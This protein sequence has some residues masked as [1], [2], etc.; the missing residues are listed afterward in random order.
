MSETHPA[1]NGNNLS[2]A[3]TAP[4]YEAV[5]DE[6]SE[7]YYFWN[8]ITGESTW[9][10]PPGATVSYQSTYS[11]EN[12]ASFNN[13]ELP[14]QLSS[15]DVNGPPMQ[16]DAGEWRSEGRIDV[17]WI[18]DASPSSNK[19]SPL[20]GLDP[21]PPLTQYSPLNVKRTL[22]DEDAHIVASSSRMHGM[23]SLAFP[24]DSDED[25][26]MLSKNQHPRRGAGPGDDRVV[27]RE[28]LETE[29]ARQQRKF[30]NMRKN[31]AVKLNEIDGWVQWRSAH[32]A[33][34][35]SRVGDTGGQW[36][37]PVPFPTPEDD[38]EDLL[39]ARKAKKLISG[40]KLDYEKVTSDHHEYSNSF[41]HDNVL[42]PMSIPY[43]DRSFKTRSR[44]P[45]QHPL[46]DARAIGAT[47]NDPSDDKPAVDIATNR[48]KDIYKSLRSRD[49]ALDA[50]VELSEV[51]RKADDAKNAWEQYLT[52]KSMGDHNRD[53]FGMS[54]DDR[55]LGGRGHDRDSDEEGPI[56]DFDALYARSVVVRQQWPWT[57]LV[58]VETDKTFY[59]NEVEDYFQNE[60]PAD[61]IDDTFLSQTRDSRQLDAPPHSI[62][63]VE[64]QDLKVPI[65]DRY[66]QELEQRKNHL[67]NKLSG[68]L[69]TERAAESKTGSAMSPSKQPSAIAA[70]IMRN[71]DKELG[72]E[73]PRPL[74][75]AIYASPKHSFARRNSAFNLS[76]TQFVKRYNP[77]GVSPS[78]DDEDSDDSVH[79][80]ISRVNGISKAHKLANFVVDNSTPIDPS[81]LPYIRKNDTTADVA[82]SDAQ[83]LLKRLRWF[84]AAYELQKQANSRIKK[85][86]PNTVRAKESATV[87][88]KYVKYRERIVSDVEKLSLSGMKLS[89]EVEDEVARLALIKAKRIGKTVSLAELNASTDIRR[90]LAFEAKSY[91]DKVKTSLDRISSYMYEDDEA[92]VTIMESEIYRRHTL[93]AAVLLRAALVRPH[94]VRDLQAYHLVAKHIVC[95]SSCLSFD[96]SLPRMQRSELPSRQWD[97]FTD[98]TGN[99]I[100]SEKSTC[101]MQLG[102]PFDIECRRLAKSL[103]YE[104]WF[105]FGKKNLSSEGGALP[106]EIMS[107]VNGGLVFYCPFRRIYH[108]REK[109]HVSYYDLPPDLQS[110]KRAPTSQSESLARP[111]STKTLPKV[112]SSIHSSKNS[113][114]PLKRTNTKGSASALAS[115]LSLT[116]KSSTAGAPTIPETSDP[117]SSA[118]SPAPTAALTPLTAPTV[119]AQG[120]P[121]GRRQSLLPRS[122]L[123][124]RQ[125]NVWKSVDVAKTLG[126]GSEPVDAH[127]NP[128]PIGLASASISETS[129]R[130]SSSPS[131]SHTPFGA[132]KAPNEY[133]N[134]AETPEVARRMVDSFIASAIDSSRK[135][136]QLMSSS[137]PAYP[138]EFANRGRLELAKDDA[139]GMPR[140][141]HTDDMWGNIQ[142]PSTGGS[143]VR[144]R[145][146]ELDM[147]APSA[148]PLQHLMRNLSSNANSTTAL[149]LNTMTGSLGDGNSSSLFDHAGVIDTSPLRFEMELSSEHYSEY[150][151]HIDKIQASPNDIR[152]ILDLAEFFLAIF[153]HKESLVCLTRVLDLCMIKPLPVQEFAMITLMLAKLSARCL[154]EYRLLAVLKDTVASCP[155]HPPVLCQAA[156]LYELIQADEAAEQLYIGALILDPDYNPALEGYAS[157]LIRQGNTTLA[158]RYMGRIDERYPGYCTSRIKTGW[159]HEL[160]GLE[161]EAVLLA[162][163]S[164]VTLNKRNRPTV[165]AVSALGHYHHVRGDLEK[166]LEYYKRGLLYDQNDTSNLILSACATASSLWPGSYQTDASRSS[167][168][169]ADARFRRGIFLCQHKS[170]KWIGLLAYADFLS[171]C[172]MDSKRIEEVLWE[173]T[174]Y[175]Y[176]YMCIR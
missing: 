171:S 134:T 74:A 71:I 29:E 27:V 97:M 5:F 12:D 55:N 130:S 150:S 99:V 116:S 137:L 147:L 24:S 112:S 73:A 14:Q 70:A 56:T 153:L 125:A 89:R 143:V 37:C 161:P 132:A 51:K 22:L 94:S 174:R 19:K 141:D 101:Q 63:A 158:M 2:F 90:K 60:T 50:A 93:E 140:A 21:Q 42:S 26:L 155:D 98:A 129:E 118:P 109:I 17:N 45:P 168:A 67:K 25:A 131:V 10:L 44:A 53:L 32:G 92:L 144:S 173:A 11:A 82:W 33:V 13:D 31:G 59:R 156:R 100:Y 154:G 84:S 88:G 81:L 6:S 15:T 72:S 164:I 139:L 111:V 66:K 65:N 107:D 4:E 103:K 38:E 47:H 136:P 79:E 23:D 133:E 35:F 172:K 151:G 54:Q 7:N 40:L 62:S 39:A 57:V 126:R 105:D 115:I 3:S 163:H 104:R 83:T 169:I 85:P 128:G 142:R 167:I 76:M 165:L 159:A 96:L 120:Q 162:Y 36:S 146:E 34:F 9:N 28:I 148:E 87:Q 43:V 176:L 41:Q 166:A 64:Q 122:L 61:L 149:V 95:P 175:Q 46:R 16:H 91:I 135:I 48:L 52:S 170:H 110:Q 145:V 8:T 108:W 127:T 80:M 121:R 119:T 18:G 69:K 68:L 117:S 157:M 106:P 49:R 113:M 75:K 124:N 30:R 77:A 102:E 123:E 58:D 114:S 78:S 1:K 160:T 20:R 86:I 152:L 138:T